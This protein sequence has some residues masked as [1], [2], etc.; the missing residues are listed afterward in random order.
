M[1]VAAVF[2]QQS[3]SSV[4][5]LSHKECKSHSH[6]FFIPTY[7]H[8]KSCPWRLSHEGQTKSITE[9]FN[10]STPWALGF[11]GDIH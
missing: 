8:G 3:G 4:W 6:C 2:S 11:H 9:E 5:N 7:L 1:L 10:K